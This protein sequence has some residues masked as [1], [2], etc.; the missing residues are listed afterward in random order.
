MVGYWEKE[1]PVKTDQPNICA[2][3][4]RKEG[5]TL[6]SV[7]SWE[8]KTTKFSF[9]FDWKALGIDQKKETL[10]APDIKDFQ[11][12]TIFNAGDSISIEP[13]K[14]WLVILSY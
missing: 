1:C 4:Y 5:K 14:G 10:I 3:I 11:K 8:D 9:Q 12:L 13:E 6:I 2:T 7:A